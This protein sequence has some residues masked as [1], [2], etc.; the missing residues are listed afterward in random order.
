[1]K[2]NIL[3][4]NN[5]RIE[6]L[7]AAIVVT[8]I[9]A[10]FKTRLGGYL[11][12]FKSMEN[13]SYQFLGTASMLFFAIVGLTAFYISIGFF[14]KFYNLAR[15]GLHIPPALLRK[16]RHVS[17]QVLVVLMTISFVCYSI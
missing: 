10:V 12:G 16:S 15:K 11:I 17:R 6:A 14:Q 1:M 5:L 2:E 8:I 3:S 4:R 9:F 7:C 13:Q